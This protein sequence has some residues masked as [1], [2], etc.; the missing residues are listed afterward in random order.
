MS[1]F[2]DFSCD[3]GALMHPL[4]LGDVPIVGDLSA[5][6]CGSFQSFL[7]FWVISPDRPTSTSP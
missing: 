7:D 5:V 3:D 2:V 1:H 4:N 6:S